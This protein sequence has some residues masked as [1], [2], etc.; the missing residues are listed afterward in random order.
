MK[1]APKPRAIDI[2]PIALAGFRPG[3]RCRSQRKFPDAFVRD[4]E[5]GS[6]LLQGYTLIDK[7][8]HGC[9]A[10]ATQLG[11][12]LKVFVHGFFGETYSFVEVWQGPDLLRSY[13]H[14]LKAT[15]HNSRV[16]STTLGL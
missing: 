10:N 9:T 12:R 16:D 1:T 14:Y 6:D 13:R 11:D 2:R 3:D 7:S 15:K 8:H 5:L 4:A